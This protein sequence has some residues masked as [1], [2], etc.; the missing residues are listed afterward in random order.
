MPR[1]VICKGLKYKEEVLCRID[2][3]SHTATH[4]SRFRKKM[5]IVRSMT[6]A[7]EITLFG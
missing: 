3:P 2:A 4:S 7:H 6:R 5:H 1:T